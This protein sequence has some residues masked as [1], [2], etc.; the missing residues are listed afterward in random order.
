M[1]SAH[2]MSIDTPLCRTQEHPHSQVATK[3]R[4]D[5]MIRSRE[6]RVKPAVNRQPQFPRGGPE[7][8]AMSMMSV[9]IPILKPAVNRQHMFP[10]GRPEELAKV[11]NMHDNSYMTAPHLQRFYIIAQGGRIQIGQRSKM[12][13]EHLYIFSRVRSGA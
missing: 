13:L 5:L 3:S 4:A 6:N 11:Y 7:E 8:L 12:F 1:N 10:R 2:R 9:L